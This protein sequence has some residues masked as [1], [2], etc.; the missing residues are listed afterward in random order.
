MG[1]SMTING[2]TFSYQME[3]KGMPIVFVHGFGEDSEIWENQIEGLKRIFLLIAPDL[4]GSGKS[5]PIED[6]SMEA[7]ADWLKELLDN[8]EVGKCILIGHS[9]GGYV[10]LAFTEKYPG[11]ITGLGLFHSTAYADSEEKKTA[12]RRGIEF[13][14]G[15][16]AAKFQEQAIPNLFSSS[17]KSKNSSK[18][19]EI[20]VKYTNVQSA[21][22]VKYYE[23]MILRP[24]RTEILRKF[25]GPVLYLV[26]E[27]DNAVPLRH[28]LEQCHLPGLSYIH[29]LKEAGHMGM[30][31]EPNK[32]IAIIE[33]FSQDCQ[34]VKP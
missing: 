13:I 19:Q 4:P 10:A 33:R 27:Q 14:Q 26:G 31:E 18:V 12:R 2:R 3:G 9:M 20:I 16:G 15:H 8:L 21:T 28:S 17:F 11:N 25:I 7:M 30:L 34:I 5:D 23:A 22:L 29:M 1:K 24:D 32:S 6:V